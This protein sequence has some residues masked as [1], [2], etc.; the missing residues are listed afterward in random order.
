[1]LGRGR[2]T[3]PL[4]CFPLL[5]SPLSFRHKKGGETTPNRRRLS[6]RTA[7]RSVRMEHPI[8]RLLSTPGNTA[9]GHAMGI[10]LAIHEHDG[11]EPFPI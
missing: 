2:E 11:G 4:S 9:P 5:P 10:P 8:A 6:P 7:C 1:M 3:L